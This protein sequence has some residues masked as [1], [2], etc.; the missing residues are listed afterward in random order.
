MPPPL[1]KETMMYQITAA[2]PDPT[3]ERAEFE[4]WLDF[5]ADDPFPR[6]EDADVDQYFEDTHEER[7]SVFAD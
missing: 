7:A 6:W 2:N 5:Q 1:D 4:E 3:A